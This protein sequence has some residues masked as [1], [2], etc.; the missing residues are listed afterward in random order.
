MIGEWNPSATTTKTEN[1]PTNDELRQLAA[2]AD[3]PASAAEQLR[4]QAAN[5]IR[6]SQGDWET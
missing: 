6:N 2:A 4:N 5:W 1:V 3:N